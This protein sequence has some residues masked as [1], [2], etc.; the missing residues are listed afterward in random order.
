MRANSPVPCALIAPPLDLLRLLSDCSALA[1]KNGYELN[2]NREIVGLGLANFA[3]AM[4]NCYT[5][6][7]SFSRSAVNNNAG[8]QTPLAQFVCSWT[9]GFVLIFLTSYFARVPMNILGSIIVVSV[10]GLVEL[11]Q[12][13]Y[14][15]KVN[16]LDMC[17]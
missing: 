5:T 14:L 9:V 11:E 7:G 2:Y 8:A 4:S 3:G 17:W 10:A 16:R 15:Y 13:V 6:T 1:R 12:I